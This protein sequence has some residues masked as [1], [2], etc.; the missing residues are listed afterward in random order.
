[1]NE[2]RPCAVSGCEGTTTKTYT[3]PVR[4]W[5]V[6]THPPEYLHVGLD[7]CSEHAAKASWSM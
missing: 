1:M 7:L 4:I 3:E 5:I 2:P 6:D